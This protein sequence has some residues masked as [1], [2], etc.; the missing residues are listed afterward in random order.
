[1][2]NLY[3]LQTLLVLL[4]LSV[5][6]SWTYG[7]FADPVQVSIRNSGSSFVD[8]F[9]AFTGYS[10]QVI[11]VS[12]IQVGNASL[13][14]GTSANTLKLVFIPTSGA[15]GFTDVIITYYSLT[16][17]MHPVTKSYRFFVANEVVITGND[18][19]LVD[20]NAIGV[21][22]NVLSNDSISNG[23]LTLTAVS[24]S[25]AGEA[26][27]NAT[28]DAILFSPDSDFLGDTWIQ[29]IA[30]DSAGNCSQGNVHILVRD[31]TTQ[32]HVVFSKFLLNTEA[33]DILTPFEDFEIEIEPSY[34]TL[35]V[36]SSIGWI[37]TP[38]AGYVGKDTFKLDLEGL[39]SRQYEISVYQKSNNIHARNDKFYVRPGLSVTFNVLNNDLL[40]YSLSS[41]T[42]PTKGTLSTIGNGSFTYTPNTGYRGIDK[43]SYTTC[44][45]DTVYC[46]TATVLIHVTDLEPDNQFSYQLQTS[47]DLPLL[48]DYPIDYTDFSYIISDEPENGSLVFY[49]GLQQ[50]N[51]PCDTLERYNMIVYEPSAG[52]TGVDH[53]E[54]YYC[55]QPSN[56]CYL[57]KV[58]VNVIDHPATENCPCTVG[59][60]WPG[61]TDRNGRVD[62]SD[63]LT[64]GNK[65][66]KAGPY[67]DYINPD[68]WFGQHA[69]PWNSDGNNTVQF[70]DANG[71]GT[72]TADD[73]NLIS[74]H[75]YQTH[76]VVVK[77]V[78]QKLPF[79]FSIIPVQYS[80]DSGDVVILDI[81]F[82]NAN[83][84]V[85]DLKGAKFSV[86]IPAFM[87][88]SASVTLDFHPNSWLAEGSPFISLGKVPWN[89]RIDG[90]FARAN[91]NGASGYGVIG[92]ITFI[93]V[94]DIEG[95]KMSN[96]LIKIPITLE[97]GTAMDSEGTLFDVEGDEFILTFDPN[98]SNRNKYNLVVYPNPA[99]DIV[100]IYINGK[101]SMESIQILDPQGRQVKSFDG[102]ELKHH[103]IDV[104]SLPVGLYYIRLNHTEGVIS[105][106]LSV[107]R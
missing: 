65:L 84:P 101:T 6:P 36:S 73:V 59:C 97:A 85:L 40:D 41:N 49:E 30:C 11:D 79:Q 66:G 13:L 8:Q 90:G 2:K 26:V 29:Y 16:T 74:D 67:R 25:N 61:D 103:Q 31:S 22:F 93:I 83:F 12:N 46:E 55:I 18:Q 75:Y 35:S 1:M 70:I 33:L 37:Y 27:I 34:G 7:Q 9:P 5:I 53:F 82:G 81:A 4:F 107:I 38:D 80:L 60:V 3:K 105:Q 68:V 78:Q 54:Y 45:Q 88:D 52:Y 24:V 48:I 50:I 19:Y 57:V 21:P 86:N 51:L 92:T 14:E 95:F 96:G 63:L 32:D 91:G 28:S 62:M 42:N 43:F 89:G 17:P 56:L 76:D 102:L 39:V 94:D 20:A 72:I 58:D 104:S 64:L 98:E 71:D 77:D 106:L 10:Y 23:I 15:V 99:T 100:D 44:F 87:M 69:S 47:K